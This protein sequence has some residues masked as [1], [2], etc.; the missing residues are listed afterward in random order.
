MVNCQEKLSI[1]FFYRG[2]ATS[3]KEE[4]RPLG[5]LGPLIA[6]QALAEIKIIVFLLSQ[7]MTDHK[8]VQLR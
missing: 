1:V 7:Y 8:L 6:G 2:R 5:P 4:K 3:N